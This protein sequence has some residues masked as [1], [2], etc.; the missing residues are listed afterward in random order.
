MLSRVDSLLLMQSPP[1]GGRIRPERQ[2]CGRIIKQG[3]CFFMYGGNSLE[4]GRTSSNAGRTCHPS[5]YTY[6]HTQTVSLKKTLD[7]LC[8]PRGEDN[9]L[10]LSFSMSK[11]LFK[12]WESA[13][14]S[15]IFVKNDGPEVF[16]YL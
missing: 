2:K 6:I 15:W 5:A 1:A 12:V 4:V 11:F 16:F 3:V 9:S 13:G 7:F 10:I 8:P 14:I